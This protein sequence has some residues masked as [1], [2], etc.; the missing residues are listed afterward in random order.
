MVEAI[1]IFAGLLCAFGAGYLFKSPTVI[2]ENVVKWPQEPEPRVL[3]QG[4][5][6]PIVNKTCNLITVNDP[7]GLLAN[8]KEV[9]LVLVHKNTEVSNYV[10]EDDF[11]LCSFFVWRGV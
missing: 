8:A 2:E 9:D 10:K 11:G 1:M 7:M 3:Y 5:E 4:N 6:F